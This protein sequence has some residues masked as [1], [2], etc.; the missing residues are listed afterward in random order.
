MALSGDQ[1]HIP[2]DYERRRKDELVPHLRRLGVD[3]SSAY[4]RPYIW[5]QWTLFVVL[6]IPYNPSWAEW[7]QFGAELWRIEPIA[8]LEKRLHTYGLHYSPRARR[9]KISYALQCLL[10]LDPANMP[11]ASSGAAPIRDPPNARTGEADPRDAQIA[12]LTARC[13]ALNREN[14]QQSAELIEAKS[15]LDNSTLH[16]QQGEDRLAVMQRSLHR[17]DQR[18]AELETLRVIDVRNER[19]K[20]AA[21]TREKDAL[22]R[23]L[24]ISEAKLKLLASDYKLLKSERDSSEQHN[25]SL[26]Q[27]KADLEEENHRISSLKNCE[28]QAK[29]LA[30]AEVV[31]L[32]EQLADHSAVRDTLEVETMAQKKQIAAGRE[33]HEANRVKIGKMHREFNEL[34]SKADCLEFQVTRQQKCIEAQTKNLAEH[35][36]ILPNPTGGKLER[37]PRWTT[38]GTTKIEDEGIME[39]HQVFDSA[40]A[41][42]MQMYDDQGT[43]G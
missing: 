24:A 17:K 1:G 16:V 33:R 40:A 30:Q 38:T 3:T 35:G 13:D 37:M 4:S 28:A 7:V 5:A 34:Q 18:I 26:R 29:T 12:E 8:E 39:S 20:T 31:I 22:Q 25:A 42:L 2:G 43:F 15:L 11:Q 41:S 14:V 10:N 21:V 23:K 19:A 6:K 27:E 36:F 9:E 32:R